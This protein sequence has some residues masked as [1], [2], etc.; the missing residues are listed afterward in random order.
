MP[1]GHWHYNQ[2]MSA[3]PTPTAAS[4]TRQIARAAGTV[5]FAI[6]LSNLAG[7]L[8]KVLT[9]RAFGTSLESEAFFAANR[10][11]EILYNLVAG[12][13]LGSAFIPT[14]TTFLTHEDRSSAWKLASAVVNLVTLVLIALSL[15]AVLLAQPIVQ[16]V[17]APGFTNAGQVALT[18]D[19]LRIMLLSTVIFGASG[20]VM[21]ILNAHQIF[22]FPALAPAMYSFG[23]IAGA[24]LLAPTLGI[25]GLAWGTVIGA[26]L[27]LLVQLPT[28]LRLPARNYQLTLGLD[29]PAVR[30]VGR[31]MA[32]RLVGVAVVQ[33]NFLINTILASQQPEG[34]L[35]GITLAFTLM[36]MPEA[37]I[38]QSVAIAALPTFSAQ[39][40]RGRLDEM[41]AALA[42]S[43]RGVLLLALPA[44]LGLVLLRTSL[45]ALIYQRGEFSEAST[46][47]V[48]WALLW[49]GLGL[50]GHSIVEIISR[51]FYAMHNTRTPVTV[52]VIAMALNAALSFLFSALFVRLGWMPHGG[53][54]LANTLATALEAAVLLVLMRRR[55]GSLEGRSVLGMLAKAALAVGGMSLA[56]WGWMT[57]LNTQSPAVVALGGVALGGLVYAGLLAALRVP[58]VYRVLRFVRSRLGRAG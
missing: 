40:A 51:A 44:S 3:T 9:A 46:R 28:L 17:L 36:Y 24:L 39:V 32:P 54:A 34:S 53:L 2:A 38:A 27:H 50:I 7:L 47:L 15:I 13:A 42:A 16:Y 21:G 58:E 33:L 5:M 4:A 55:L 20:L 52:G 6:I 41:R 25:Y 45:V 11:T 30:E 43:L 37:A 31:L 48:A 23:W 14:F 35:T 57:A 18:A 19:L 56:L 8:A 10:F 26:G 22:L 1:A 49:Y 29:M 12:G